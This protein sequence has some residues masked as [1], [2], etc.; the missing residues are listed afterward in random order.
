[1]RLAEASDDFND[2]GI[3]ADGSDAGSEP[4]S[5]LNEQSE[6]EWTVSNNVADHGAMMV[7][8]RIGGDT[9]QQTLTKLT[10]NNNKADN[11][12]VMINYPNEKDDLTFL[13][14]LQ[15]KREEHTWH[16]QNG[17]RRL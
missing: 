3:S 11:G 16:L 12:G 9:Y 10:I 6:M 5:S 2:S 8:A 15:M 14:E 7:N 17:N 4:P 1:M 13:F